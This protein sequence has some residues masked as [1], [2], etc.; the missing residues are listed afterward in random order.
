MRRAVDLP[1]RPR[2]RELRRD[3]GHDRGLGARPRHH[4]RRLRRAPTPPSTCTT[5]TRASPARR[6]TRP[7]SGTRA[8]ARCSTSTS[9]ATT[10]TR[11]ERLHRGEP[12]RGHERG[13]RARSA[14]PWTSRAARPAPP[15]PAST[16][17][18]GRSPPR[19]A[20]RSRPGSSSAATPRAATSASSTKGREC[21]NFDGDPRPGRRLLHR[22]PLCGDWVGPLQPRRGAGQQRASRSSWAYGHRRASCGTLQDPRPHGASD[23]AD[24]HLVPPRGHVRPGGAHVRRLLRQRRRRSRPTRPWDACL[25]AAIPQYTRL[26]TDSNGNYLDGQLDEVRMSFAA[27]LGRLDRD[28]L[29]QPER[30]VRGRRRVLLLDRP[31]ARA[32]GR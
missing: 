26:G 15:S 12:R 10:P 28:G 13:A 5:V 17:R 1:P 29:Q 21:L 19:R 6:R 24:G 2:D 30:P 23:V 4:L 16:S 14:A 8:T 9:R 22:R 31:P 20:S 3:D 27:R 7:A 32:P 11:R 25:E 18:T